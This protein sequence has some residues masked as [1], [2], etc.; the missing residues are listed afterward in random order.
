MLVLETQDRH[1]YLTQLTN[2][3]TPDLHKHIVTL[4]AQ[5]VTQKGFISLWL[6]VLSIHVT[7]ETDAETAGCKNRNSCHAELMS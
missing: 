2:V 7:P 4:W 1:V 6:M 3:P 5:A